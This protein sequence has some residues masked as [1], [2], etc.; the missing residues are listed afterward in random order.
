MSAT[1]WPIVPVQDD[2]DEWC[3]TLG[4]MIIGKGNNNTK[5]TPAIVPLSHKFHIT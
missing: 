3:G 1:I 2:D 4:G 5:K